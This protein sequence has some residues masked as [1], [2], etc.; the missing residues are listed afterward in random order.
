MKMGVRGGG[1]RTEEEKARSNVSIRRF[2]FT[3]I[4][5]IKIVVDKLVDEPTGEVTERAS[6]R[7]ARLWG[8][9]AGYLEGQNPRHFLAPWTSGVR[10]AQS[11][12]QC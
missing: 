5:S 1:G 10:G 9:S 12:G 8:A 7:R 11:G 6:A 3:E 2:D 4:T